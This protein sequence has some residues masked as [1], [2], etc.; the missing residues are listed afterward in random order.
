MLTS[1][2]NTCPDVSVFQVWSATVMYSFTVEAA[3]PPRVPKWLMTS[4]WRE[5]LEKTR[6]IVSIAPRSEQ[7]GALQPGPSCAQHGT[8]GRND[9]SACW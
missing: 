3:S 8:V 6:H 4:V 7:Q 2:A 1:D 5:P 9:Q